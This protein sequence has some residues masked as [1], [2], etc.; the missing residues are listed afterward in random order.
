MSVA[1]G[2]P[3]GQH[4][5]ETPPTSRAVSLAT[6]LPDAIAAIA[7]DERALAERALRTPELS[8]SD[9][10]LRDV[11]AAAPGA[12]GFIVVEGVVLKETVLA[13]RSALEMLN[14]G[15]ILAPPLGEDRQ[16]ESR[17]TS[18]YLAHGPV[19]LAALGPRFRAA[20][21]RW[22]PVADDLLDRIARQAHRASAHLA[23]LHVSRVEERIA[24]LFADLSE[25][26]GRV[27]PD[28]VLIDISLTHKLIGGLVGAQRPTVTLALQT[29][30]DE[31]ALHRVGADRW[32]IPRG[33]GA[34][35]GR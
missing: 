4:P 29:L 20:S 10:D 30:A 7:E 25:R 32:V 12:F 28:G 9:G 8:G 35:S 18:R 5:E 2:D 16:E 1:W 23:M 21:R 14:A 17:A 19:T 33:G 13:T 22:P 11:L 26:C 27:T 6:L 24:L 15:D 3:R 31:G 34:S